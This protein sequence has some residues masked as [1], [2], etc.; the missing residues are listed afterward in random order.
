MA[1]GL[2]VGEVVGEA[3]GLHEGEVVGVA[4][5]LLAGVA[6]GVAVG[7]LIGVAVG[8]K[9]RGRRGAERGGGV[10]YATCRIRAEMVTY[11]IVFSH[12]WL[13]TILLIYNF[14]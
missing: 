2:L 3:V 14:L 6:V 7:L 10:A 8:A 9:R 13:K 5:G 1:V 11:E 4:V 12:V